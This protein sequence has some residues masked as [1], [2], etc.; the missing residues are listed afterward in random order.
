MKTRAPVA[1]EKWLVVIPSGAT[2]FGQYAVRRLRRSSDLFVVQRQGALWRFGA[3]GETTVRYSPKDRSWSADGSGAPKELLDVLDRHF[4]AGATASEVAAYRRA[5]KHPPYHTGPSSRV[6]LS[7]GERGSGDFFVGVAQPAKDN[8]LVWIE[9]AGSF[10]IPLHYEGRESACALARY[11]A[12]KTPQDAAEWLSDEGFDASDGS[13]RA[14][15]R[16]REWCNLA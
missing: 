12:L 6:R 14:H 10:S 15:S 3:T 11:R 13:G 4:A 7:R 8:V 9:R 1:R 2:P 16:K 5:H